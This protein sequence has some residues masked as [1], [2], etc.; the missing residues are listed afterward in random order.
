MPIEWIQHLE[1]NL[2]NFFNLQQPEEDVEKLFDQTM[3]KIIFEEVYKKVEKLTWR[4]TFA[5]DFDRRFFVAKL[6]V[7][8][9]DV[10]VCVEKENANFGVVFENKWVVLET[11]MEN[12]EKREELLNKVK[13]LVINGDVDKSSI[14]E[15]LRAL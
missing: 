11:S 3:N 13:T 2:Q 7:N 1:S 10:Q 9:N 5:N 6:N 12:Y 15:R 4:E 8:E 14:L